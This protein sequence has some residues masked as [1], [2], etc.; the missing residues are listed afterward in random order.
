MYI[1]FVIEFVIESIRWG[2]GCG[3][4]GVF[5]RFLVTGAFCEEV[6]LDR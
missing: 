6:F 2:W 5:K 3:V 1:I 4:L